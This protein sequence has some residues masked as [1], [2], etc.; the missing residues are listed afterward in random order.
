MMP[1]TRMDEMIVS[2]YGNRRTAGLALD[3]ASSIFQFNKSYP[4]GSGRSRHPAPQQG[5]C[6]TEPNWPAVDRL[7]TRAEVFG[8]LSSM[9]GEVLDNRNH[10]IISYTPT[11]QSFFPVTQNGSQ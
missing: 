8:L 9:I 11:W 2:C 1:E 5:S 6:H 3:N 7:A 10:Y 4:T